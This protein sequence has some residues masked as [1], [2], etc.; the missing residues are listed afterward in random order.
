MIKDFRDNWLQDFF[1]KDNGSKN[2][3]ANIRTRLFRKLQL[4]DD[5]TCVLDLRGP[6]GNHF[7]RLTGKL[8]GICSI[9][10]NNQ[11]RSLFT[12]NNERGEADGIYLDAHIYRR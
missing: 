7:E 8:R 12:W 6:P 11:Y 10:V 2:I 5:A 3:P 4:I 1:K 9:R